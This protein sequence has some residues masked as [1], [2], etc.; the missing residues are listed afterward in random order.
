M[1]VSLSPYNGLWSCLVKEVDTF[2]ALFSQTT[3]KERMALTVAG[4]FGGRA[5]VSLP[6]PAQPCQRGVTGGSPPSV[7]WQS[8]V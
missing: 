7:L 6:I 2:E 5:G 4:P 3:Y 8:T 1:G